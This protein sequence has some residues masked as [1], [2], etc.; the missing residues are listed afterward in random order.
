MLF[1]ACKK[2]N[3]KIES[4]SGRWEL[5]STTEGLTGKTTT[6]APGQGNILE[7]NGDTFTEI[8]S[9][10]VIR[11]GKYS[12]TRKESI[13]TK[14]KEDFLILENSGMNAFFTITDDKLS[15]NMD[16]YDSGGHTYR[17]IK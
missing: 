12:T 16:A 9:N 14:Q 3:S 15:L 17:R 13:I 7:F 11:E 6:F 2:D 1:S 5:I 4:L 10:K 8:R